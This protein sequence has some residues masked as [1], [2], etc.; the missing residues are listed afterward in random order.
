[1]ITERIF[2]YSFPNRHGVGFDQSIFIL[3]FFGAW[4]K[5]IS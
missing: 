2:F 1:M 5:E 3:P 4:L